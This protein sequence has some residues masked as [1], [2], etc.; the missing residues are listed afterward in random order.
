MI[1][2]GFEWA[3]KFG[4]PRNANPKRYLVQ[5]KCCKIHWKDNK[6]DCAHE[7]SPK[8][9]LPVGD[10]I[11]GRAWIKPKKDTGTFEGGTRFD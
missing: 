9:E 11:T 2:K 1:N 3:Y 7:W 10:P 4:E 5:P 6:Y 8:F